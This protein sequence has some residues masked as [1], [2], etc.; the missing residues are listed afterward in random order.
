MQSIRP[1]KFGLVDPIRTS[2][3]LLQE[4]R[5]RELDCVSIESGI[6][7]ELKNVSGEV[8]PAAD[9]V[10]EMAQRVRRS[11][12]THLLGCVDP[13]I[14]YADE[15]CAQVGLPFNGLRR[16]QARRNKALMS[17]VLAAAGLRVPSQLESTDLGQVLTWANANG[18]PV[19]IKPVGSGGSDNVHLCQSEQDVANSFEAINGHRNLMGAINHTVLVQ[20]FIGGTEY[21]IDCV[22]FDGVHV[23]V[24]C[25]EYQKGSHNGRAFVYEKE[26]YL[27][28]EHS[29]SRRLFDF[30]ARALDAL[31]FRLGPSHMELK[32][33]SRDEIV[34]I[35]VGP[36]LSG[37]D[38]H[39]LVRDVRCDGRSQVE[40]TIDAYLSASPPPREYASRLHAVRVYV[41][42]EQEG[43][44]TGFR[45]LQAIERLA[46]HRRT[47]MHV[48]VGQQVRL[49]QDL[50][51]DAGWIDLAHEDAD[52]LTRDEIELDR[53]KAE[54]LSFD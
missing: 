18:F 4:L 40:L 7:G 47:N 37:G 10:D 19:V 43:I 12:V 27:P 20:E 24:D 28:C 46:S 49:T 44:L 23:P 41:I 30:A 8:I 36:R 13:S 39:K 3:S 21:V 6:V 34:F 29:I 48:S 53:L 1:P 26:F 33:N 45:H 22:S 50:S 15:L 5:E 16:S 32:I 25:F 31:D 11:G 52:V 2:V 54:V 14:T 38:T 9:T 42:A 35:E 17:Q 51:N